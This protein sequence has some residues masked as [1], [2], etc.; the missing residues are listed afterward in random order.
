M[1]IKSLTKTSPNTLSLP[2]LPPLS[3][4]EI[5][6]VKGVGITFLLLEPWETCPDVYASVPVLKNRNKPLGIEALPLEVVLHEELIEGVIGRVPLYYLGQVRSV[7]RHFV[8]LDEGWKGISPVLWELQDMSFGVMDETF[9]ES[10]AMLSA[11]K[12]TIL[13]SKEADL[14]LLRFS[15]FGSASARVLSE[16]I[17]VVLSA[18]TFYFYGRDIPVELVKNGEDFLIDRPFAIRVREGEDL[19]E[20]RVVF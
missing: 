5:V 19:P 18:G 13:I 9:N 17:E 14:S 11:R 15:R 6:K 7:Q 16:G 12:A 1:R 3:G 10:W 20:V 2:S 4:G 8:R